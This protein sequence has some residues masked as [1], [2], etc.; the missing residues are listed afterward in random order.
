[1]SVCQHQIFLSM[2]FMSI[3]R[4][5]E[6]ILKCQACPSVTDDEI[7]PLLGDGTCHQDQMNA[8]NCFDMGDCKWCPFCK[9][10]DASLK[11]GTASFQSG[12]VF[13]FI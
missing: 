9:D 8:K 11:L 2:I 7:C 3:E 1:M 13:F 4:F 6:D 10:I 12:L 5:E